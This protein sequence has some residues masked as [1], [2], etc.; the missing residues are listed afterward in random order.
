VLAELLELAPSGVE[1]VDLDGIVEYAVYGPP[2]ERPELHDVRAAAGAALV[3]I[4]TSTVADDWD[5]RWKQFHRPLRLGGAL[6][7]RPPWS[8]PEAGVEHEVVIDPGRAFGTGAH[9]TTRLCLELMLSLDPGGPF[10]DWGCG[11]GVLAIAAARMGW[12]PVLAIDSE[13]SSV[14]ATISNARANGVTVRAR[15]ADLRR[16]AA[17]AAATA[18]ANLTGPLLLEVA[19]GLDAAPGRLVASGLL[20]GEVDAVAGA[21]AAHG[22]AERERRERDGWAALLL[23]GGR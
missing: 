7:V 10:V 15:R 8:P 21:F 22:L 3:E 12:D 4:S 23:A 17:P 18:A 5:E 9:P 19:A 13:A 14:E 16:S 20:T 6:A 1:Q 11:S 2:G